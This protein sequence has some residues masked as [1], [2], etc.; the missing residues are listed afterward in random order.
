[1]EGAV[2][3]TNKRTFKRRTIMNIAIIRSNLIGRQVAITDSANNLRV[4][5]GAVTDITMNTDGK[6]ASFAMI[7]Q[8]SDFSQINVMFDGDG[9]S[10]HYCQYIPNGGD[11]HEGL[12]CQPI[13]DGAIP[14][15]TL[16]RKICDETDEQLRH[17]R[18]LD[19]FQ[20]RF[21]RAMNEGHNE[22]LAKFVDNG[23]IRV[24]GKTLY[25]DLAAFSQS[26]CICY[27]AESVEKLESLTRGLLAL[28]QADKIA[29]TGIER[30]H[31]VTV[32][33]EPGHHGRIEDLAD[34]YAADRHCGTYPMIRGLD[35]SWHKLER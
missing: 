5:S 4:L 9:R 3:F 25:V 21:K 14:F 8:C 29:F 35:M 6:N 27:V 24:D 19:S 15:Y 1:M 31:F 28:Y 30:E 16:V 34:A 18:Y 12:F 17:E 26:R 10:S 7:V 20:G 11:A 22:P 33:V 32:E 23:T 13:F 2:H